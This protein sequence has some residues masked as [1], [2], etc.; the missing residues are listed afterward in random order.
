[1]VTASS[2]CSVLKRL[3]SCVLEDTWTPRSTCTV[4]IQSQKRKNSASGLQIPEAKILLLEVT[5]SQMQDKLLA[6]IQS[7]EVSSH[8]RRPELLSKRSSL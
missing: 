3:S 7:V 4:S 2:D 5:E 1:M 8:H 6:G